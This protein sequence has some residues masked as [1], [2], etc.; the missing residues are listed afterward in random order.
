M[1]EELHLV[2]GAAGFI[3]SNLVK[4]LVANGHKVRCLDNFS[5]GLGGVLNVKDLPNLYRGSVTDRWLVE[6]AMRD[7]THVYHLAALPS[8]SRSIIDPVRTHEVNVMGTLNI[9]EVARSSRKVKRVVFASSSSLYGDKYDLPSTE[10]QPLCMKSP[11]ALSKGAAER[12]CRLYHRFYNVPTVGL[13]FF[14]VFGPGQMPSRDGAVIPRFIKAILDAE[15]P[16]M[17]GRSDITRDFT[18]VDQVISAIVTA[19]R[20]DGAVGEIINV[21]T[22]VERSLSEVL[23]RLRRII[24]VKVDNVVTGPERPGD[25]VRS[26]ASTEKMKRILN[27]NTF[28]FDLALEATVEWIKGKR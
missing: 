17:N 6:A 1:S 11:Y 12:Y 21:G 18:P 26:Q 14:N 2:T 13:R 5:T 23:F 24:G 25:V 15:P 19:A 8:V 22:G 4:M 20:Y 3:G 27:P 16:T 28:D 10:G 7:V 9:L